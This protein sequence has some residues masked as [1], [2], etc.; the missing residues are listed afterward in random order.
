MR[1]KLK[2]TKVNEIFYLI[3]ITNE[4]KKKSHSILFAEYRSR[5]ILF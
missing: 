5:T 4:N 2:N 3:I 1:V